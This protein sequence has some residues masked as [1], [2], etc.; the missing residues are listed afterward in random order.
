MCGARDG[1]AGV[2]SGGKDAAGHSWKDLRVGWW[3]RQRTARLS[4]LG[5]ALRTG[6][7]G[8]P[9]GGRPVT[10]WWAQVSGHLLPC[11][12]AGSN[13]AGLGSVC[14]R[15]P[16]VPQRAGAA[17]PQT[18]SEQQGPGAQLRGRSG[19]PPRGRGGRQWAGKVGMEPTVL[20]TSPD[21]S[22]A[23]TAHPHTAH[24]SRTFHATLEAGPPLWS[25]DP[26]VVRATAHKH[27]SP[28]L[29][30]INNPDRFNKYRR[31]TAI[32]GEFMRN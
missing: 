9:R 19:T 16:R 31:T 2:G 27:G 4:P 14:I 23:A 17:R 11:C 30:A 26:G 15:P 8:V 32:C 3:W 20:T 13:P 5:S 12:P 6:A 22:A 25:A 18:H 29:R 7:P 24:P 1:G 28:G 10:L 21:P